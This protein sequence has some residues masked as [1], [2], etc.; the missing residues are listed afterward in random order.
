MKVK[1]V[2][3]IQLLELIIHLYQ[4]LYIREDDG[5]FIIFYLNRHTYRHLRLNITQ[6]VLCTY[7]KNHRKKIP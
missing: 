3:T 7:Y 6:A 5:N 4:I 1:S 2:F